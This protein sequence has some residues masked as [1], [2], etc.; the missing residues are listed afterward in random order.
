MHTN[1][2][3]TTSFRIA[4][5]VFAFCLL[6]GTTAVWAAAPKQNKGAAAPPAAA[7]KAAQ[8]Q[9]SQVTTAPR[10]AIKD[11]GPY[12]DVAYELT[13]WDKAEIKEWREKRD[14]EVGETL[15][16]YRAAW[17]GKLAKSPAGDDA[18]GKDVTAGW[19]SG[20]GLFTAGHCQHDRLSPGWR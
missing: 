10:A 17:S 8:P 20:S 9:K 5:C 6:A 19:F 15:S 4:S 18:A 11:W 14:G 1:V 12:L 7:A 16:A 2:L 3:R 13:Y